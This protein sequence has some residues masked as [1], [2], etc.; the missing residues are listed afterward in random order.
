[1]GKPVLAYLDEEHLGDP[2]FNLP[3]VN[4]TPENLERVLTVL[5][6]VPGLRDRLGELGRLAVERYQSEEALAEVWARVYRHLWWHEPLEL[7]QT[8]HFTIEREPRSFSEDPS[9]EEFW[10]VPV[11]DLMSEIKQALGVLEWV[12]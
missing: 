3:I 8:Q 4:T 9:T 11:D 1:L 5:L 6:L 10:P 12:A 7:E 2:V